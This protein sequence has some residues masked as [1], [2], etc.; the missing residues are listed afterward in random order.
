[1]GAIADLGGFLTLGE[2]MCADGLIAAKLREVGWQG[3]IIPDLIDV[4]LGEW[5]FGQALAQQLRWSQQ[6]RFVEPLEPVAELFWNGMFLLLIAAVFWCLGGILAAFF[7]A[8]AAGWV[9]GIYGV[10]YWHFGGS[11]RDLLL[12]PL[13]DLMML[14]IAFWCYFGNEV[15]WRGQGF[16]VGKG[17]VLEEVIKP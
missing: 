7:L 15:S 4:H 14:F 12:L 9:W 2:V 13:Q 10:V 11:W 6:L 16:R 1:M 3:A 5:D 17:G 8:V